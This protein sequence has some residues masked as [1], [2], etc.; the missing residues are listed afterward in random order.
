VTTIADQIIQELRTAGVRRIFG[1]PGGGSI[2]DL[3]EAAGRADLPFSLA[4]TE[5]S[6]ALMASAQAEITG[7]PGA[8]LAT[9]GPGAAALMNG[10][11]HAHLDRVPL[12][13]ITDCYDERAA[14]VMQHQALDQPAMFA[15]ATRW[16]A[17]LRPADAITQLRRAAALTLHDRPG[18][19]HLDCPSQVTDALARALPPLE[20]PLAA[21]PALLSPAA[22]ALL[23]R[24]RRPLLLLGLGATTRPVAAAARALCEQHGIP[25]LVTYKAKGVVPDAHPWFAV[26]LTHG[27][28]ERP[29]IERADLLLA[30]GLD[31]VELLARPWRYPQP[32]VSL[33]DWTLD[34]HQLPL[35][36]A[37][38]GD[39]V[40]L[41]AQAGACLGTSAWV[42]REVQQIAEAA[43]AAMRVTAEGGGIAP[44]RVVELAAAAYPGAR[45]TVDA[46]AHMFPA[47][48]LWPAQEPRDVLISNGLATMGFAL[49]AA[50]GA[51]LLDPA[52]PTVVLTGDGG[53]LMC[54]AE[55]RTA[56][57]ERL[58]LR[59]VVFDD[60]ALSLIEIKQIQRG[61]R[62]DGV[63]IGTVD[64]VALAASLGVA[65][66][67][68][69]TEA[70]LE[71]ALAEAAK[72]PGPALIAA[73]VDPQVYIPTIRALRG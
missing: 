31:P 16:S 35:A 14:A 55:L 19:V 73:A 40:Q 10:L 8:C 29:V 9:L 3:I 7:A 33:S 24:A 22:E 45:L 46:G 23:H 43:R 38:V 1:V 13:A 26:V 51:A 65:G 54:L 57:R 36:A 39:L 60:R 59:I 48:A 70:E 71:H 4:H 64:W 49:P 11:A 30:V 72:Q 20:V 63:I 28:I 44:F 12:L 62:R 41:V 17:Q 61:Y 2:A 5:T 21:S 42:Q 15:A 68:T 50:I 53:L 66:Y 34:Q 32:I 25:A 27:A 6:A 69:T 56:A 52:R 18:P 58:S 67:R 37:C 47:M